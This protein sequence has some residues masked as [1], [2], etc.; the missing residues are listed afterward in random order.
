LKKLRH[1]TSHPR[2]ATTIAL[3]ASAWQ[4]SCASVTPETKAVEVERL[5]C[6]PTSSEEVDLRL[7]AGLN[8][9]SVQPIYSYVHTATTGTDKVVVGAKLLVRPP[10]TLDS[11]RVLRILQCHSARAVLGKLDPSKFPGDP[12]W[13]AGSWLEVDLAPEAGNLAVTVQA[14]G[15]H[16][17][18]EV[19]AHARTFAT[20]HRSSASSPAPG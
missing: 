14:Q 5:Q 3:L 1:R 11:Q 6:E 15:V 8:V 9:L 4:L 13:L 19:L 16:E 18:L 17:N 2:R 12:F 20:T 10:E 7:L